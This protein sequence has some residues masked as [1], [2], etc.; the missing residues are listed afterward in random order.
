MLRR[1]E[2]ACRGITAGRLPAGNDG[3]GRR[4]ELSVGPGVEAEAGQPALHVAT[5]SF[6]EPRSDLRFAGLLLPALSRRQG[7]SDQRM[8]TNRGRSCWGLPWRPLR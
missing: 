6:V 5:L 4:V 1:I 2:E 8:P 7:P 3:A